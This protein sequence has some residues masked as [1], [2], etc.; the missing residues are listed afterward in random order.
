MSLYY[1]NKNS[2]KKKLGFK[3]DNKDKREWLMNGKIM[4][5]FCRQHA[6]KR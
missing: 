2:D 6:Y 1:N 4:K 5:I 3:D